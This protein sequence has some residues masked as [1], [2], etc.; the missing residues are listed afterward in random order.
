MTTDKTASTT[1]PSPYDIFI[2]SWTII[3]NSFSRDGE[4]LATWPSKAHYRWLEKEGRRY[5]QFQE[6]VHSP[7]TNSKVLR[8]LPGGAQLDAT[9]T[10]NVSREDLPKLDDWH[11]NYLRTHEPTVMTAT[12]EVTGKRC[13]GKSDDGHYLFHG[14]ES[15]PGFFVVMV[16]YPEGGVTFCNNIYFPNPN[17]RMTIGPT[18]ADM[19][20]TGDK[21]I[22][23]KGAVQ[24]LNVQTFVRVSNLPDWDDTTQ[25]SRKEMSKVYAKAL[26][27]SG[28]RQ[29]LETDPAKALQ[30]YAKENHLH[31][32][33]FA[34]VDAN[35][36]RRILEDRDSEKDPCPPI[37]C[38]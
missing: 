20:G 14:S 29:T 5:L 38:S 33:N 19:K 8:S 18:L 6:T 21:C 15:A 11:A 27:D 26:S 25:P 22:I 10:I 35:E 16:R 32:T 34:N 13:V 3:I 2:G 4:L 1:N 9:G 30:G 37:C 24:T 12:V 28:F 23:T 7:F 36:I 31:W 17:T